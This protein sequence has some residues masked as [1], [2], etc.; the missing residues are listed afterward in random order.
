MVEIVLS[1]ILFIMDLTSGLSSLEEQCSNI[2]KSA[3]DNPARDEHQ[4]Y[5]ILSIVPCGGYLFVSVGCKDG[6]IY[7]GKY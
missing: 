2:D 6:F 4:N 7:G 5:Y 3:E 1:C